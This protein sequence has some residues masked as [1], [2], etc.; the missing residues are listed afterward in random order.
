M[1]NAI[2][3]LGD[4]DD[5]QK[6]RPFKSRFIQ[7]G[8]AGYPKQFG[9]V[10]ITKETLDKFVN[11]LVDKPVI[12][13]H[14]DEI[15]KE[16]EVGKV[17]KV[18]F[19]SEDGWFWCEG[20]LTDETAINL[21][22]DKG[23]SV[24]CSYDVLLLDDEG[25]TENNIK[26][27]KEFLNGRFT[28]LAIV[29]NPRYER[30]NIVVNSKTEILNKGIETM[31]IDNARNFDGQEGDWITVNGVHVFVKKGQSK[32]EA[33][34]DFIEKKEKNNKAEKDDKGKKLSNKEVHEKLNDLRTKMQKYALAGDR[35][36]EEYKQLKAEYQKTL[37]EWDISQPNDDI[38]ETES[39]QE[40]KKFFESLEKQHKDMQ[41]KAEEKE[42]AKLLDKDRLQK[43][44]D[45]YEKN[46]KYIREHE[47][48]S[49]ERE[50]AKAKQEKIL[51]EI[52]KMEE[53]QKSETKSKGD[54][55]D[56]VDELSDPKA[57]KDFSGVA[58]DKT[59]KEQKLEGGIKE[60]KDKYG[61]TNFTKGNKWAN[62]MKNGNY[63]FA[64]YGL[65]HKTGVSW[66]DE[67]GVTHDQLLHGKGFKTEKG[68][69]KWAL[70]QLK[71]ITSD[72]SADNTIEKGIKK[73]FNSYVPTK[74]DIPLLQGLIDIL[75]KY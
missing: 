44:K 41:K 11:T 28:H 2:I 5:S 66:E 62:V 37:D 48:S 42:K 29:E 7:A 10:L 46:K 9:N 55:K 72:N 18:W 13:N 64:A 61:R 45:T 34:K 60:T 67:K 54:I 38:K 8:I 75:E 27:D 31:E 58:K 20:Y 21:I 36:N 40:D 53:A 25:G 50:E 19:N 33:V 14:K 51:A 63:Y 17:T 59:V 65:T 49:V 74:E 69:R 73:I 71:R 39:K 26:Y 1:D 43:Y 4:I 70:E 16:D 52:Q 57:D 15:K 24:S 3:Q 12:I 22:K 23:W 32:E 47:L 35:T 68:A 30:A 56:I 6:G